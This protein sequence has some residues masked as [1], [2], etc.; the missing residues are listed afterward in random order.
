MALINKE[1]FLQNTA[2]EYKDVHIEE[3][4]GEIRIKAMSIADQ[5]QFE[6]ESTTIKN[7]NELIFQL[8]LNCCLD[9]KGV[10]LFEKDD[11]II[12]KERSAPV[13]LKLFQEILKVNKLDEEEI[14][15]LAKN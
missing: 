12:I 3:L 10:K 9:E 2:C 4:G 14:D 8:I 15:K 1:Q 13:I 7:Q 6:E 5:I 11:L